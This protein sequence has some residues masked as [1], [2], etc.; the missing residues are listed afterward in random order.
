MINYQV[1]KRK[2]VSRR[3][4]ELSCTQTNRQKNKQT[5]NEFYLRRSTGL[6]NRSANYASNCPLDPVVLPFRL[7]NDVCQLETLLHTDGSCDV[8]HEFKYSHQAG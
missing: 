1:L 4:L 2:A 5:D 6:A 7:K 8:S 3:V